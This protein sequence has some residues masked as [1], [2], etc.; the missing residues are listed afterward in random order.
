MICVI[1]SHISFISLEYKRSMWYTVGCN[2]TNGEISPVAMMIISF[3]ISFL[4]A[5]WSLGIFVFVLFLITYELG[6]YLYGTSICGEW[7]LE[8]RAGV[9]FASLLGFI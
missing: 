3:G 1:E 2:S 5:P 8:Y 7:N 9:I 4:L 6:M